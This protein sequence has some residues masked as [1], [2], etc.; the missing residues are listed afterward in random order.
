MGSTGSVFLVELVWGRVS[1]PRN[2]STSLGAVATSPI[3]LYLRE[4]LIDWLALTLPNSAI[5]FS[6]TSRAV[7]AHCKVEARFF[8]ASWAGARAVCCHLK[9]KMLYRSLRLSLVTSTVSRV[10][11]LLVPSNKRPT[12]GRNIAK[13]RRRQTSPASSSQVAGGCCLRARGLSGSVSSSTRRCTRNSG[14]KFARCYCVAMELFLPV[15]RTRDFSIL[16]LSWA[17]V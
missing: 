16:G 12:F 1:T 9:L 11:R 7:L 14:R 4:N 15:A 3:A 5:E 13:R 8:S 10:A 6:P 17:S 2:P